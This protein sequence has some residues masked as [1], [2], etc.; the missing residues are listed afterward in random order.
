MHFVSQDHFGKEKSNINLAN[1]L[2]IYHACIQI[3]ECQENILE[4]QIHRNHFNLNFI[5]EK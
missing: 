2:N 5:V 3:R 4:L 1:F